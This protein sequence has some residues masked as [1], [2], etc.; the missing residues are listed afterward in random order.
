MQFTF[1]QHSWSGEKPVA[2][3]LPEDWNIEY[4]GMPGDDQ[5]AMSNERIKE[6]IRNPVGCPTLKELGGKCKQVVILF[7]DNTRATPVR[8][9]A[10]AILEELHESG[11][12]KDQ[13]RFI[14]ALGMHGAHTRLDFVNKLG[15]KIVREY[16][17]YNHNPYENCVSVGKVSSGSEIFINAEV[18]LCDLKIGIGS[19]TPHPF[20][21]WG[22]GGKI[23]LPGVGYVD[24]LEQNHQVAVAGLHAKGLNPVS[25]SGSLDNDGMRRQIEE[26]VRLTG[27]TFKVD[28]VIN[29]K[30]EIIHVTA[31]DP[32]AQHYKG[33]EVAEKMY[34]AS[35]ASEK[36]IVIVNAN[37]KGNEMLIA[38]FLAAMVVKKSGGYIV[39]VNFQPGGQTPHYLLGP[40]GR[41]T[42]G[43]LWSG[44]KSAMPHLK[45][46]I[47]YSAYPD[48]V[49]G[50]WVGDLKNVAW[51]TTWEEALAEL[52]NPG[53]GAE[54][55][56]MADGTIQYFPH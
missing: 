4:I 22:G 37:S 24:S 43:R 38:N 25:G 9:M 19:I 55:G 56:V 35:F 50:S 49:S 7:D 34:A 2:I 39:I 31:G 45:K 52:G 46:T 23:M 40:F 27:F 53:A 48:Y 51:A 36:D 3:N 11:V 33:I 42:G 44:I 1:P 5:P 21:G 30:K 32:I 15:E 6:A 18:M 13:I 12:K 17:V 28:A 14:C 16:P 8:P 47:I 29:S 10:E 41:E 20:N 26:V 54:V